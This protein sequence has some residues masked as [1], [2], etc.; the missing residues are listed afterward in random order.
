MHIRRICL[1]ITYFYHL[2]QYYMYNNCISIKFHI[3]S[4]Q[5]M[6]HLSDKIKSILI[7]L[8]TTLIQLNR[9]NFLYF[10]LYEV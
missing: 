8:N 3:Q 1:N 2:L 5:Y 6:C 7:K 9:Y 10:S 4:L